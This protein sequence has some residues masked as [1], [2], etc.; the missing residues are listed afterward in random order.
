VNMDYLY[1]A[2][3]SFFTDIKIMLRTVLHML[4]RSGV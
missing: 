2:G 3:W 1:V 4:R